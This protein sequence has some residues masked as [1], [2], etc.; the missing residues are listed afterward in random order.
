MKKK[1]EIASAAIAA[2]IAFV[3]VGP[4]ASATI[5]VHADSVVGF[6][7]VNTSTPH[8]Y[9]IKWMKDSKVSEGWLE[10]DGTRTFR[11]MNTVVRQDMAAFLRR[12]AILL[13]IDSAATWQPSDAD[14]KRFSDVNKNTP[15]AED[16]LWMAKES[17]TT[18][19]PDGTYGGMIPVYHQDMAAFIHRLYNLAN[20]KSYDS[21]ASSGF[22]DVNSSTPHCDDILWMGA[23]GISTGYG[24]RN[25]SKRYEGM[26]SVYRQ[27]MAA[28]LNRVNGLFPVSG[29]IDPFDPRFVELTT[30]QCSPLL[31][32]F[33]K[34][35][36]EFSAYD[37]NGNRNPY[38]SIKYEV[39]LPEDVDKEKYSY[40]SSGSYFERAIGEN[41]EARARFNSST[42]YTTMKLNGGEYTLSATRHTYTI[43]KTGQ[44]VT[45]LSQVNTASKVKFK[46]DIQS[47][48]EETIT[49]EQTAEKIG[50]E[51]D[52]FNVR[53]IKVTKAYL[54][55]PSISPREVARDVD[56]NFGYNYSRLLLDNM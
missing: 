11:P 14:W 52:E 51:W 18:G 27:D 3:S 2:I 4:T 5:Q 10:A 54:I 7:D 29:E 48:L 34:P 37:A 6:T 12:E 31:Y 36:E 47:V 40:L 21:S 46:N 16:I 50:L 43:P 39:L 32:V 20:Y 22:T 17:I 44:W 45:D 38:D 1:K 25:G 8:Y 28:F 9:D 13:G 23:N 26:T 56:L 15:H 42:N 19:Y 49:P 30:K 53:N 35:K 33:V 41:V 24:N 55:I